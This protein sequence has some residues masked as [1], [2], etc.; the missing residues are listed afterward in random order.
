MGSHLLDQLNTL[1]SKHDL[2]GDVRGAGLFIG[3]ELVDDR[4]SLGPAGNDA[5]VLINIMKEKGFL[6]ASDGP[7]HNVIK[8]KSP[9][10]F[11]K[12]NADLLVKTLDE[13]I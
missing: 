8:I 7:D 4:C 1:K 12:A 10:V 6:L 13:C 9:M 2:I 11:T 3:V 5:D